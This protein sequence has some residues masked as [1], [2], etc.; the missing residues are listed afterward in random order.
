MSTA[1]LIIAVVVMAANIILFI[2]REMRRRKEAKA[3]SRETR[4]R[5][6]A[7]DRELNV[8]RQIFNVLSIVV[9]EFDRK[10]FEIK[11]R[12]GDGKR[13]HYSILI[14]QIDTGSLALTGTHLPILHVSVRIAGEFDPHIQIQHGTFGH[15]DLFDNT[16]EGINS[17]LGA[18]F[19]ALVEFNKRN[20]PC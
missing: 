11:R 16:E 14:K 9:D 13:H 20:M 12:E 5:K 17:A 7:L 19:F 15:V 8:G 10:D 3:H 4:G 18:A 1:L 6:R 2:T